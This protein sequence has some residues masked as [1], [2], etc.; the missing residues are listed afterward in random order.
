MEYISIFSLLSSNME[1]FINKGGYIILFIF[2]ILEGVP[3][4]G[5]VVP[6]HIAIIAGGFLAKLG[7]LDLGWTIVV[8]VLG[9]LIGDYLGFYFGRRYGISFIAR[10]RPYF[11]ITDSSIEKAQNL[12]S[13][14]TGKALV[15][16]RFTPATR[17]LMP[18]LVGTNQTSTRQFWIFNIIGGI[19]WVV[20]SVLAGYIFGSAYRAFSGYVGKILLVAIIFAIVFIWGYKFA[21]SRFHIFKKFELFTLILNIISLGTFALVVD[22]LIDSNFRLSFDIL[23]NGFMDKVNYAYPSLVFLAKW[24]SGIGGITVVT[25]L[26][27]IFVAYMLIKRK[28][29]SASIM[30]LSMGLTAFFTGMIKAFFVSPR[31]VNALVEYLADPSF[32]SGHSSMIAAFLFIV[33]YLSAYNIKSW[34][35]RESVIAI[36]V[37][38]II[39]V[40]MSRLI[41]NVHWLSDVV[42]GWSLGIFFATA[43]ILLVRYACS[44]FLKK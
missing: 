18:F 14:H 16:G 33:A 30:F 13:R 4:V 19:S 25:I 41:L 6:G 2:T 34:V 38:G 5:M 7:T 29:R 21:N 8:S 9:A 22:K 44:L 23:V 17:A 15:I 27:I 1:I 28:W 36:C 43:S 31:P 10:L 40:G 12:L 3:L 37:L 42:A 11:F 24:T 39:V 26:G 32:P 35:K 20:S